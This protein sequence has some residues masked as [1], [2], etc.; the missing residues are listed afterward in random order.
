MMMW[1]KKLVRCSAKKRMIQRIAR[2]MATARNIS[3][4]L[5][6]AAPPDRIPAPAR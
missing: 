2:I 5:S 3:H 6:V 1:M 4:L